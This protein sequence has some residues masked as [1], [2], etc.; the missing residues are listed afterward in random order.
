MTQL[1]SKRERGWLIAAFILGLLIIVSCSGSGW[2]L[3][4]PPKSVH[5]PPIYP[6]ATTI[7]TREA[8]P[9]NSEPVRF[10]TFRTTD[11][12]KSVL[13]YYSDTLQ[14]DGWSSDDNATSDA[15]K[16][17]VHFYWVAG[18]PVYG[19]TVLALSDIAGAT[20]VEIAVTETACH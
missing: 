14:R 8:K 3:A 17:L 2:S 13:A 16:S 6:G 11:D 7:Q 20:L 9:D 12:S 10:T 4:T 19:I 5:N 18:C 1:A 15:N